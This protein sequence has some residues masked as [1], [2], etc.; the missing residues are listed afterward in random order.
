MGSCLS[1][2]FNSHYDECCDNKYYQNNRVVCDTNNYCNNE[3]LR[4]CQYSHC[5]QS[6]PQYQSPNILPNNHQGMRYDLN[7]P[8]NYVCI[9]CGLYHNSPYSLS[10]QN[11][12]SNP[13]PSAPPL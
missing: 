2:L 12:Q 3:K 8:N 5:Q 11:C 9:T 7:N 1:F 6:Y 10:C 4:D 13:K